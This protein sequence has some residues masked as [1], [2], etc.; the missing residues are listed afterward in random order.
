MEEAVLADGATLACCATIALVVADCA[1]IG[2]VLACP[3]LFVDIMVRSVDIWISGMASIIE[4]F[5]PTWK[6]VDGHMH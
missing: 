3:A 5:A 2:C 1:V 4:V 6:P